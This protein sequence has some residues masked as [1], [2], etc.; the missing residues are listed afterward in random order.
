MF[1]QISGAKIVK[2]SVTARRLPSF[3]DLWLKKRTRLAFPAAENAMLAGLMPLGVAI[4]SAHPNPFGSYVALEA[5]VAIQHLGRVDEGQQQF[6]QSLF[7]LAA[8]GA[9]AAC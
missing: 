1:L 2:F 8:Y 6:W 7:L 5:K 3:Y 4:R 9:D